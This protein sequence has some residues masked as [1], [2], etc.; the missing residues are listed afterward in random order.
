MKTGE[1]EALQQFQLMSMNSR[2]SLNEFKKWQIL[3]K[4]TPIGIAPFL[5]ITGFFM[6]QAPRCYVLNDCL[7]D[8]ELDITSS[9]APPLENKSVVSQNENQDVNVTLEEGVFTTEGSA[10]FEKDQAK[11]TT[12]RLMKTNQE[13]QEETFTQKVTSTTT[14][15]VS[16][17]T[18]ST[19]TTTP[20]VVLTTTHMV[21]VKPGMLLLFGHSMVCIVTIGRR[22]KKKALRICMIFSFFVK[23]FSKNIDAKK[24]IFTWLIM[25]VHGP[26]WSNF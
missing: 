12:E 3:Q 21:S 6:P 10:K 5:K 17:G 1:R 20:A 2:I 18:S 4:E 24:G 22:P 14:T 13:G 8:F 23:Q 15:S 25:Y 11:T 26:F 9:I 19:S 16:L 7:D